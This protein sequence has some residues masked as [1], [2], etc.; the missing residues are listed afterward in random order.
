MTETFIAAIRNGTV[1]DLDETVIKTA[2]LGKVL[3][4]VNIMPGLVFR[5]QSG[6]IEQFRRFVTK[7][8]MTQ[9]RWLLIVIAVHAL[10]R[11]LFES[12]NDARRIAYTDLRYGETVSVGVNSAMFDA[13]MLHVLGQTLF[14]V[15]KLMHRLGINKWSIIG[16]A[17]LADFLKTNEKYA[18]LRYTPDTIRVICTEPLTQIISSRINVNSRRTTAN[19]VEFVESGTTVTLSFNTTITSMF[20]GT[21]IRY[22]GIQM[23]V[24]PEALA[25]I[26]AGKLTVARAADMEICRVYRER[27]FNVHFPLNTCLT[28]SKITRENF[29]LYQK[30]HAWLPIEKCTFEGVEFSGPACVMDRSTGVTFVRCKFNGICVTGAK[31]QECT[32]TV[33]GSSL[34]ATRCDDLTYK[35]RMADGPPGSIM[36][37][38]SVNITVICNARGTCTIDTCTNVVVKGKTSNQLYISNSTDV[39]VEFTEDQILDTLSV[40]RS[41]GVNVRVHE[42]AS[43]TIDDGSE[44]NVNTAVTHPQILANLLGPDI[45]EIRRLEELRT[46]GTI[47]AADRRQ[48]EHMIANLKSSVGFQTIAVV[49]TETCPICYDETCDRMFACLHEYCRTCIKKLTMCSMCRY[50]PVRP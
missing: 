14:V 42:I 3:E 50:G 10:P 33:Y 5:P 15:D 44:A 31:L 11:T 32:G 13:A 7:I 20:I 41:T 45:Q 40:E 49:S 23:I 1:L 18:R 8:G 28:N 48:L 36:V 39:R 34:D 22:D 12:C 26:D 25:D 37:K 9:Y 47:T 30:Y 2:D 46:N 4:F 6:T 27:G 17:P 29:A 19:W 43:L 35:H 24:P 21:R 38:E 16:S